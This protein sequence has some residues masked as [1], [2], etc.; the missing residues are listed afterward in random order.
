MNRREFTLL[1]AAGTMGAAARP[2]APVRVQTF[3][4]RGC[5]CCEGWVAAAR[6]AG[7]AVTLR[8]LDR[9]ERL[10][11][12][13]LSPALA[14]CHTSLVAG[15]VVEGHVPFDV[16]A[17][18]QRE[19]PRLRGIAAP[20]MPTGVPDM[21]APRTGPLEIMTIEAHPRVYARIA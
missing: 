20:G 3:R 18:L 4:D 8:D 2:A 6:K 16:I 19:R 7:Y 5:G 1:L 13:A 12:F 21:D 17:R 11:R 10:R 15:Y 9:E 14:G